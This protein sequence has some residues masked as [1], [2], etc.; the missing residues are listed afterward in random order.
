[1]TRIKSDALG[2]F[3]EYGGIFVSE[4]LRPAIDQ[5]R[6]T[7]EEAAED[8]NFLADYS[9]LLS[10]F[11]GRPTP[12]TP[13]VNL[14]KQLSGGR[15][16]IFLKREDLN[17]SGAHKMN[18][19]LGQGL[20]ME[21][22]GKKRVIAETGAGQHGVATAIMA[23]K[24]GYQATIYMGAE[25]VQ[26][27]YSNVFWMRQL[28]A[29]V[30]AVTDGTATLKDAINAALRDW[31]E[32]YETTHYCLGT[33]CGPAPYPEMVS[34]FQSV[35]S[36]ELLEQTLKATGKRPSRIYASVGGGSNAMGA[37]YHS[38]Q[39]KAVKLIGVEAAGKGIH[40]TQHATR[41]GDYGG[42][43]K[44]I[45]IK[46]VSQGYCTVFLQDEDGQMKD[47]Y[48]IAAGL[49]YVGVSPIIAHLNKTG[50]IAMTQAADDAVLEAFRSML[51]YEGVIP[52]LESSHAVAGM[53]ADAPDFSQDEIV[54][55]VISGRGDK[56]LFNMADALWDQE[57]KQFMIRR[58]AECL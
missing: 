48:S 37:F 8:S 41:L 28:G 15:A 47:T 18:N 29:E 43:G 22:L 46:G 13:A 45:G 6:D 44:P 19:V 51:Q 1:M 12:L 11:C 14:S 32:H 25:D 40:T 52:A 27:Q 20:L 2:F 39:D 30:I 56:D 33:A 16:Q 23:A 53:I 34:F 35:I 4:M 10:S 3:G 36:E 24:F 57:L 26:R 5:L 31:A 49:D 42:I 58:G 7:F 9:A 17:H 38:I 54:V 55:V 21:R 50:N